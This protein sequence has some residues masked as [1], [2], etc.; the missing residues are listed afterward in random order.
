M[1][2]KAAYVKEPAESAIQIVCALIAAGKVSGD[3]DEIAAA[4]QR[5][6]LALSK[7]KA[8]NLKL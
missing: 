7:P 8:P 1:T 6:T 5:I 2:E 3:A 4:H